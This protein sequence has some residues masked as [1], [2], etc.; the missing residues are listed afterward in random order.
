MSCDG[1]ETLLLENSVFEMAVFENC[2]V[3][4]QLSVSLEQQLL[5]GGS[6]DCASLI[7]REVFHSVLFPF[8]H[9]LL[10]PG[11]NSGHSH[12]WMG[13]REFTSVLKSHPHGYLLSA[14]SNGSGTVLLRVETAMSSFPI[15][16][17]FV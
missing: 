7:I 1:T 12:V 16:V 14:L 9:S 10:K 2:E 17:A 3:P 15:P 8:F 11:C 6:S 4:E 13:A 5:S